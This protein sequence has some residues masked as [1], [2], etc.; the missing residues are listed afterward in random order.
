MNATKNC[1]W[2]D[3]I[4][5]PN[6]SAMLRP[7]LQLRM[8]LIREKRLHEAIIISSDEEIQDEDLPDEENGDDLADQEDGYEEFSSEDN[9]ESSFID[10]E[11]QSDSSD[12][13]ANEDTN[14]LY[15]ILQVQKGSS[16]SE[17]KKSYYKLAIRF[18]PDK[19]SHSDATARMKEINHAYQ[20]LG[21]SELRVIYG[22]SEMRIKTFEI[23]ILKCSY[24]K[25][26]VTFQI[27][28]VNLG[29]SNLTTKWQ[30]KISGRK[31]QKQKDKMLV[32]PVFPAKK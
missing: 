23:S 3:K 15:D 14:K 29:C 1:K 5:D 27:K 7:L 26:I 32:V 12:C 31:C 13:L 6:G 9:Y 2:P 17:I 4:N 18:H 30:G 16:S 21:N 10:D 22:K 25:L 11:S 20:I 24:L 8:K 19:C 28:K